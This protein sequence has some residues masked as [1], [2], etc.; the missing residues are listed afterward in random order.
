VREVINGLKVNK[1][2]KAY[3]DLENFD[4]CRKISHFESQ[5]SVKHQRAGKEQL[6]LHLEVHLSAQKIQD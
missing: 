4:F 3:F 5:F 1:S 2:F 6:G